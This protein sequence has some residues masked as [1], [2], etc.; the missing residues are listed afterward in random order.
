MTCTA[1]E[2]G[3]TWAPPLLP[4][5]VPRALGLKDIRIDLVL[6]CFLLVS[7]LWLGLTGSVVGRNRVCRLLSG[8]K[9]AHA[10]RERFPSL[11]PPPNLARVGITA[12][13]TFGL[14]RLGAGIAWHAL[15]D[16]SLLS[17]S[18]RAAG[19]E[20]RGEGGKRN[21]HKTKRNNQIKR[22]LP[23]F[24]C[25]PIFSFWLFFFFWLDSWRGHARA[26]FISH[27]YS[28][29][30]QRHRSVCRRQCRPSAKNLPARR[31]WVHKQRIYIYRLTGSWR[32]EKARHQG[33]PR[34]WPTQGREPA[35][36]AG[37]MAVTN[38]DNNPNKMQR[39]RRPFR[40]LLFI[41]FPI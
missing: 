28:P 10:S 15:G 11:S 7:G 34:Q 5:P 2:P 23:Y 32:R 8:G 16:P 38:D 29:F 13:K 39:P 18:P 40:A 14:G 12:P 20:E 24:P 41:W 3:V 33:R 9:G 35:D 21:R 19:R 1:A 22:I 17:S 30:E 37:K 6:A 27:R 4:P 26:L 25:R 36:P 31:R